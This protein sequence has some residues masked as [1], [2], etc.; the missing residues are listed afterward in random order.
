VTLSKNKFHRFSRWLKL[1]F[2]LCYFDKKNS[3]NNESFDVVL[4]YL[5]AFFPRWYK[6][7]V[8]EISSIYGHK[9]ILQVWSSEA[10]SGFCYVVLNSHK[11]NTTLLRCNSSTIWKWHFRLNFFLLLLY[12][13]AFD[14]PE[15]LMPLCTRAHFLGTSTIMDQRLW[16]NTMTTCKLNKHNRIP[17]SRTLLGLE[18]T[19]P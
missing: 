16:L 12:M 2:C 14:A 7:R 19:Y 8:Y 11:F 13:R 10:F 3:E 9:S 18:S 15:P 1:Y 5:I 4:C 17:R 6:K